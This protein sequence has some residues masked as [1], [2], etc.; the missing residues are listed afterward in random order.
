MKVLFVSNSNPYFHNTNHYRLRALK[1][2][3]HDIVVFDVRA[4]FFH[5]RLREWFS[6]LDKLDRDWINHRLVAAAGKERPDVCLVVGGVPVLQQSI[7]SIRSLGIL[8]ILWTTDAPH[9]QFFAN[10]IRTAPFYDR[11]FCAGSEAV[12]LLAVSGYFQTRWLPFAADPGLHVPVILTSEDRVRYERLVSFVGS[13]YPNR[14]EILESLVEFRPGIWGP[15]W[16]KVDAHS[17]L[18]P[19][20]EA[21]PVDFSEWIKIYTAARIVIVI[22]YQD[23]QVPCHQ[24]SPKLFEAMACGAFVICDSQKD[25]RQ[26]FRDGEH[27]VFFAGVNDLKE[28]VRY[29]LEHPQERQ[30]IAEAGRQ[31]VTAKHAYEC[32]IKELLGP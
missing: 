20:I 30:K 26:L 7:Q 19:F 17:L 22:H 32:R 3:G 5:P 6:G 14:Q 1:A 10:I 8:C 2:L 28:K 27:V 31:E 23:G 16:D 4:K 25:A 18:F 11:V 9:P 12:D 13:Y 21:R 29:Y 24:A 15:H